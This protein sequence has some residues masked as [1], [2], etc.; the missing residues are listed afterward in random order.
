MERI[1]SVEQIRFADHY[2]I[3]VLGVCEKDL[4]QRAGKSVADEIKRRFRGGRVLVCIGKGN[5]GEDGKII[6][7]ELSKTHGFSVNTLTVSNG[8]FKIFDKKFDIIV[9]CIFGTGLNREVEGKYK[10][11]IEKINNSGAFIIS[12]DIPSGLNGDS[13]K[14]QGVA[15]KANLTI[16]IQELKL[17]YFLG[18]GKDY[19]GEVVAKDIGISVWEENCVK[20]F[21]SPSLKDFFPKKPANSNKGWFGKVAIIGGCIDYTGSIILSSNALVAL[22]M[23]IGYANMVVPKSLFTS[24]VGK[25]PECL[26]TPINDVD[27]YADFDEKTL[28]GLLDYNCI[29]I[30]VGAGI[31]QGV[32]KNICYLLRNYNGTL[33]IDADGLNCL[34]KFGVD[35]L[36]DKK[37]KVILTPHVGEFSR[38]TNLAKNEILDNCIDLAKDFAKKYG[39]ILLLKNAVSVITN[40]NEVYL[41]TTGTPAMAKAG[42][43]DVLTGIISGISARNQDVFMSTV[44]SAYLFG[45]AGEIATKEQNEYTVTASDI[46]SVL[47][48]AMP[49]F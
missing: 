39:V 1:L 33:V 26:L 31:S 14:V 36:V 41:N 47:Y 42:S 8:I 34:A 12:C 28:S 19:C 46:I 40:G 6:A 32:Y 20:R 38:L 45:K 49:S 17:G 9:D 5:N 27:G 18:D 23:G 21:S 3:N 7:Q 13:G 44:A 24:Y 2:N 16:A 25:V 48:K 15:V 29:A 35:V 4:I 43:G 30:G 10:T 37:C 11:A 22:K